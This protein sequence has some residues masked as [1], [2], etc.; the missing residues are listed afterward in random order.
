MGGKTI[1]A[2]SRTGRDSKSSLESGLALNDTLPFPPPPPREAWSKLGKAIPLEAAIVI[3]FALTLAVES[4][5]PDPKTKLI[6]WQPSN[7]SI[8]D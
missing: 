6:T 7:Q 2:G 1:D 4:A 3:R 8:T 5:H